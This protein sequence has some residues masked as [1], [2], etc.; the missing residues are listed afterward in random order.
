MNELNA[1]EL[2]K[3][4]VPEM[5]AELIRI[6]DFWSTSAVD[7]EFGGFV[8]QVDHWGKV[9]PR[10]TKGVVLN[11]RILWTF[12]AAYKQ[13]RDERY[14]SLA[15]RAFNYLLNY[16][17]DVENGGLIWSVDFGGHPLNTRK[18]AYAQGFGIYAFS[19]YFRATGHPESLVLAQKLYEILETK[20]KDEANGGYLEALD[21]SWNRMEDMRLSLKDANSPKSMNTHLHILEPYTNLYRVWPDEKLKQNISGLLSVF[22]DKIIDRE[23]GHFK[24][25]FDY[26]WTVQS[27]MVSYG[28]D[29][30]GAWLLNEAAMEIDDKELIPPIQNIALKMVDV[31]VREA[32]TADGSIYYEKEGDH[33]DKD[34]HWWPQAEAMVGL[35]D[36]WQISGDDSY[37]KLAGKTW[38]FI[39]Q[40][41]LDREHGE[42]FWSIRD[43]GKPNEKEDKAGFWKCPYHNSRALIEI[44]HR[45]TKH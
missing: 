31:T 26:D 8:G 1:F 21:A 33:L 23:T 18:Q 45:L 30:E 28:H 29:I 19:E 36:A 12:S 4:Q 38:D 34:R 10:A 9:N 41:L 6:L 20:F 3:E 2:L 5:E 16:F 7:R 24:L 39:Q 32:M 42:W 13:F 44:I 11:A 22:Y 15:T 37:L 43:D 17:W 40:N 35:T 14:R 25:F 27:T